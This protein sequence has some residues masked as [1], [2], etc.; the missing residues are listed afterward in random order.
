MIYVST[1]I[2]P[3]DKWKL[4]RM[5]CLQVQKLGELLKNM[6]GLNREMV[7]NQSVVIKG[8]ITRM[9]SFRSSNLEKYSR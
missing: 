7:N 1:Y 4:K 9:T 2:L 8:T 6:D 3:H 5:L